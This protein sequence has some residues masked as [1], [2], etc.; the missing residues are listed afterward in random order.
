MFGN[1]VE[2]FQGSLFALLWG[3]YAIHHSNAGQYVFWSTSV[4][5][6]T[7]G[8]P[9]YC[10][11]LRSFL[12]ALSSTLWFWMWQI[13][14][15]VISANGSSSYWHVWV[16]ANFLRGNNGHLKKGGLR[17]AFLTMLLSNVEKQQSSALLS[18]YSFLRT[19]LVH[20]NDFYCN[21]W[22]SDVLTPSVK[23]I[24]HWP[25]LM[26]QMLVTLLQILWYFPAL[27]VGSMQWCECWCSAGLN[28]FLVLLLVF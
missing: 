2:N 22:L 21:Y 19:Q 11:I 5:R 3:A 16:L 28:L 15:L 23:Q 14:C 27:F 17:F 7:Q 25:L 26:S 9:D 1:T 20:C 8:L 6:C 4:T 18:R 13:F 24:N 12:C 10:I